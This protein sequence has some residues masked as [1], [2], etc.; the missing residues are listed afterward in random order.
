MA[1]NDEQ[2][3]DRAEAEVRA[4][5]GWH[6]APSRQEVLTVD[7]QDSRVVF[8]PTLRLTGLLS[9]S[10]NGDVLD[11]AG[12]EWSTTGQL[13]WGRIPTPTGWDGYL[14]VPQGR[15]GGVVAEVVHGWDEWPLDVLSVI[16]RLASRTLSDPG[17]LVQVGG[18]RVGTGA[19]G[20]PLGGSLT[21]VD[22]DV[23]DR[24]RIPGKL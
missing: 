22:R 8:L 20:L 16:D 18:V 7:G 21:R 5:C 24:Y 3:R 15:L 10:V 2:A 9:L 1:L 17:N 11:L 19:D 12:V 23:L 6:V 4:Y 14:R 13:R